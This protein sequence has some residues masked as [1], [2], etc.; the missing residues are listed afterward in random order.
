MALY[1]FTEDYSGEAFSGMV[2]NPQDRESAARKL[3]ASRF[4][5]RQFSE[6]LYE[7]KKSEEMGLAKMHL[8]EL[9]RMMKKN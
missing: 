5:P 2:T 9:K 6:K 3:I 8:K 4:H 1:Y 7:T